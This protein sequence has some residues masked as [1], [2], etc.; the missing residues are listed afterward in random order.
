M[1]RATEKILRIARSFP[2]LEKKLQNWH[3]TEFDPDQFYARMDGASHV[4]GL[5]ALFVLA[6]WNPADARTK[7]WEFDLFDFAGAAD[8]GN[9]RALMEWLANPDWP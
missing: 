4:E 3:P 8:P 9:R 5:C 7:G 6:V 1:D 2:C